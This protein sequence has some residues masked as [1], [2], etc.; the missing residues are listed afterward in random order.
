M[1]EELEWFER[2]RVLRSDLRFRVKLEVNELKRY[3][4]TWMGLLFRT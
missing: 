3:E 2:L 1:K 4:T